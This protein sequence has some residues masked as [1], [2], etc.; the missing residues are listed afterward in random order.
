MKFHIAAVLTALGY[1]TL[2]VYSHYIDPFP[3]SLFLAVHALLWLSFATGYL[4]QS[5][6]SLGSVIFWAVL[7]RIIACFAI[8]FYEDDYFRFLW[9]GMM[10]AETGNP[11]GKVPIEY[12]SAQWVPERFITILD[13]I[14][15][16]AFPTIYGIVTEVAF[17]A[18]YYI[19]PGSPQGL[20][21][22]FGLADLVFCLSIY[23]LGGKRGLYIV[24][25]CPL[26]VVQTYLMLHP[27]MIAIAAF[28]AALLL[29]ARGRPLVGSTFLAFSVSARIFALPL[30]PFFLLHHSWRIAIFFGFLVSGLFLTSGIGSDGAF[31]VTNTFLSSFE[32]NSSGFFILSQVMGAEKARLTGVVL[33]GLILAY[34]LYF[35]W[36]NHSKQNIGLD[37][38]P[39]IAIFCF[40]L[41]FSPVANSWYFLWLLP[42]VALRPSL[43]VFV[44]LASV[45][46]SYVHAGNTGMLPAETAFFVPL[47][48]RCFEFMP[49]LL[50]L[51]W[52][53]IGGGKKA[54]PGD[55][56]HEDAI[57]GSVS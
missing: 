35:Y 6:V 49:P 50:V 33:F 14:N 20:Q 5:S 55:A 27:E 21:V 34:L 26:L 25:W 19:S 46:L 44:L 13:Q 12:F 15:Y 51:L 16:P 32:F 28:S 53:V 8:P 4:K 31:G 2:S 17:L 45:S 18:A 43:P 10:F 1:L 47:T 52:L 23:F 11:Y 37:N 30:V 42:F 54:A 56:A 7:F 9:D 36:K 40:L 48:V 57:E 3:L 22:V 38:I 41:F 24:G 39:G 29:A